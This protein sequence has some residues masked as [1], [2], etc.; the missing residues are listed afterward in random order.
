[1]Y[2]DVIHDNVFDA[3]TF[4]ALRET[5]C[6]PESRV[7]SAAAKFFVAAASNGAPFYFSIS[8]TNLWK[9]D[10]RDNAFDSNTI[11]ALREM[12]QDSEVDVRLT[13]LRILIDAPGGAS[14][15]FLSYCSADE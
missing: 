15:Q 9:D 3:G 11:S 10:L 7:R 2:K 13:A 4:A 5:L 1:L 12:L 14:P 8:S 6:H